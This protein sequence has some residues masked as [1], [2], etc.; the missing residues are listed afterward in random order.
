MSARLEAWCGRGLV[1][2]LAV[3]HLL[4]FLDAG[5]L[6]RDEANCANLAALPSLADVWERL[7]FDSFPAFWFVLLRGWAGVFGLSDGAFR[8]LGLLA[9]LLILA[10]LWWLSRLFK[11]RSPLFGLGLYG[12]CVTT[13]V[14]GDS[15]RAYGLGMAAGL[16]TF[17]CFWLLTRGL[18]PLRVV[19]GLVAALAAAQLVYY[20]AVFIFAAGVA[21]MAVALRHR[22]FARLG[23]IAAICLAAALT[24]LP[25]RPMFHAMDYWNT[26]VKYPVDASWLYFKFTEAVSANG[27]WS[28]YTWMLL[29][30]AGVIAAFMAQFEERFPDLDPEQRDV[31]MY[32]G[33][34]L[35]IGVV[36]YMAFLIQ[37][38]YLMQPW[39][40]LILLAMVGG[41]V[42][43]AF[44]AVLSTQR[45]RQV[46]VGVA[47]LLALGSLLPLLM[48]VQMRRT[49]VDVVA[50]H[51]LAEA[52][53][54]DYVVVSP[55]YLGVT[56]NRYYH[57]AWDTIPPVPDH[58][59]H[60]YDQ[61]K[62]QMLIDNAA[63]P[64]V[65]RAAAALKG[66]HRVYVVGSYTPQPRNE[67]PISSVRAHEPDDPW[68]EDPQESYWTQQVSTYIDRHS[69]RARRLD[70]A[71]AQPINPYEAVGV[72]VMDGYK[73]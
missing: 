30:L 52:K 48:S 39:Y 23:A 4:F 10:V 28:V 40:F 44:V 6:W 65:D 12:F 31:A 22:D 71:I 36:A 64:V 35:G 11:V 67:D 14:Y 7:Q 27:P 37:L 33:L 68:T 50:R 26:L 8:G 2:I 16:L 17:G 21:G 18:T 56:V 25:Y 55:W 20:G 51:I 3:F 15:V 73:D 45:G 1:A 46:R 60:R 19:G 42:D 38:G 53:P 9:G 13:V 72:I 59:V 57:G 5:A 24:Y 58:A 49:N 34:G 69:T 29:A 61:F 66:G 47:A 41:S 63:K 43:G 70:T 54:G 62:Q 32:C